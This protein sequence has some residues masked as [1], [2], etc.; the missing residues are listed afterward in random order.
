[1]TADFQECAKP[2]TDY[3]VPQIAFCSLRTGLLHLHAGSTANPLRDPTCYLSVCLSNGTKSSWLAVFLWYHRLTGVFC[4]NRTQ[5]STQT[6]HQFDQLFF[7]FKR[8][9]FLIPKGIVQPLNN[10]SFIHHSPSGLSYDT[11]IASSEAS[12]PQG[13]TWCS[14]ECQP[15]DRQSCYMISATV[16]LCHLAIVSRVT[17]KPV[18]LCPPRDRQPC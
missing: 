14:P 11:S 13:A 15:R 2:D 17:N 3:D 5:S 7:L 4:N 9:E 18:S 1:M 10:N 6:P 8:S 12:S 16:S